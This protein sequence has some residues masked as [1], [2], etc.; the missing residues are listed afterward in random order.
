[1]NRRGRKLRSTAVLLTQVRRVVVP[2]TIIQREFAR[3]LPTVLSVETELLFPNAGTSGVGYLNLIDQT[4]QKTG[5]AESSISAVYRRILKRLSRF[6][7]GECVH[8][9]GIP[10]DDRW[11]SFGSE[12]RSIFVAV[13]VLDP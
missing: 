8:A 3:H 4:Q 7:S 11:V 9:V 6:C 1:M 13:V 12:F 5:V 10:I 2:Q